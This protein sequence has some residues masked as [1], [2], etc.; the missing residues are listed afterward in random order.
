[1]YRRHRHTS[2]P[3][4]AVWFHLNILKYDLFIW[5]HQFILTECYKKDHPTEWFKDGD[6]ITSL[7]VTLSPDSQKGVF[8]S[9]NS[10]KFVKSIA[11]SSYLNPRDGI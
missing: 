11:L 6:A 3:R 5:D 8:Q 10:Q 4:N 9:L 7:V 2:S 1:M